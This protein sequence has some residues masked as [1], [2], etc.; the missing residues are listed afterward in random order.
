MPRVY[1]LLLIVAL[2]VL[3]NAQTFDYI[4]ARE[5]TKVDSVLQNIFTY[6]TFGPKP[7]G[8]V[9]LEQSKGWLISEYQK[10]G[11]NVAI[12][13]FNYNGTECYNLI[14]EK[15]GIQPNSWI[16]VGAHYD[17]VEDSPGA[18]DNGTGVVATLQIAKLIKDFDFEYGIRII[19]FSAEEPGIGLIGSRHYVKNTL[20]VNDDVLFMLNL[21]QLGGTSGADNS[22]IKCERDQDNNPSGNNAASYLITDTLANLV[23]IYTSLTPVITNAYGS[24]YIPFQDKGYVITGLYQHSDYNNFYHSP[25]DITFNV[26]TDAAKEVIK[27]ALSAVLYFGQYQTKEAETNLMRVFPNPA[28]DWIIVEKSNKKTLRLSYYNRYGQLVKQQNAYSNNPI[29]I[30]DLSSGFYLIGICG[31]NNTN[32]FYAKL[33]I[34]P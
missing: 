1:Y 14:V 16:I 21:D 31:E 32:C 5:T 25:R 29:S 19:N 8:S 11:Y 23:S 2:S 27:A 20:N 30:K 33:I 13:T 9:Q 7:I 17:T 26:D 10:M 22:F 18:N 3:C 6:E 15:K 28:E 24:D 12:D 34:A 4:I